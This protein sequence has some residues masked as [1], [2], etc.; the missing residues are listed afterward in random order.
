MLLELTVICQRYWTKT[1]IYFQP[2][3]STLWFNV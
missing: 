1:K 2:I 3:F